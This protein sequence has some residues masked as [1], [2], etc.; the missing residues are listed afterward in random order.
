MTFAPMPREFEWLKLID[1]LRYMS[2]MIFKNKDIPVVLEGKSQS[3]S[4]SWIQK[5]V[6]MAPNYHNEEN[7]SKAYK[8]A[9]DELRQKGEIIILPA[10]KGSKTV[11]LDK[12]D[13]INEDLRQLQT[14][15]YSEITP[16]D[17]NSMTDTF[18]SKIRE[19]V[20]DD[21]VA[22]SLTVANLVPGQLY[23]LPKIH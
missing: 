8:S 18:A 9:I 23:L 4:N 17:F 15:S 22:K 20:H 13:Y 2:S 1:S 19:L 16:D 10:N 6:N 11:V 14:V 7:L 21:E 3:L 5:Y 12:Q